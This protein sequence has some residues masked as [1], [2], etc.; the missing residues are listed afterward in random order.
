[1]GA[2]DV[3]RLI[4]TSVLIDVLRGWIP[5]RQWLDSISPEER[6]ISVITAVVLRDGPAANHNVRT[7]CSQN[8]PADVV[9]CDLARRTGLVSQQQDAVQSKPACCCCE[10]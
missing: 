5:A 3:T 4:E 7:R 8:L 1:M 9:K 2:V 10:L 6:F